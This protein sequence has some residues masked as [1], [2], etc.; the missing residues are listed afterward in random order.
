MV[1]IITMCVCYKRKIN[2]GY[3]VRVQQLVYYCVQGANIIKK[4]HMLEG[5]QRI[6]GLYNNGTKHNYNI[7]CIISSRETI[8]V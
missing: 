2:Q 3:R 1:Y 7:G 4:L 6:Y 5:M 8:Q